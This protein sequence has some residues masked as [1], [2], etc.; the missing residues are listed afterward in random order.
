MYF[1]R[2]CTGKLTQGKKV[3]QDWLQQV[4][5]E[6]LLLRQKNFFLQFFNFLAFLRFSSVSLAIFWCFCDFLIVSIFC[7]FLLFLAMQF[8][9]FYTLITLR[10]LHIFAFFPLRFMYILRLCH[11]RLYNFAISTYVCIFSVAIS[12]HLAFM[13]FQ[14]FRILEFLIFLRFYLCDF[15]IACVYDILDIHNFVISAY[16]CVFAIFII[17]SFKKIAIS[18]HL[19][20]YSLRF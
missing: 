4:T 6:L 10:F 1:K 9:S 11:S 13:S 7:N 17:L 12:L 19:A 18:F 2:S 5:D 15:F 8:L 3:L 16:F 14:T 20:F